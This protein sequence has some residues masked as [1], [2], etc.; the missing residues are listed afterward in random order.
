MVP[1]LWHGYFIEAVKDGARGLLLAGTFQTERVVGGVPLLQRSAPRI[2]GKGNKH[3]TKE[4]SFWR[5]VGLP[6]DPP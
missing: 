2:G 4:G 1:G 5:K 6:G 3:T